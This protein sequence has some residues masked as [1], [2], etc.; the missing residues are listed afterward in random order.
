MSRDNKGMKPG[1]LL[2]K[3]NIDIPERDEH[4]VF[5]CNHWLVGSDTEGEFQPGEGL[6]LMHEAILRNQRRFTCM[7]TGPVLLLIPVGWAYYMALQKKKKGKEKQEQEKS[8]I[9][10]SH[11]LALA[12]THR[13]T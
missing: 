4:Y 10:C 13:R 6:Q 5:N 12:R 11:S 1:W 7:C 3:V 8:E 9:I 2:E